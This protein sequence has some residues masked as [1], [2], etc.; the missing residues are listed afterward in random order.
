MSDKDNTIILELMASKICHDL[1]SPVGAISN[2]VEILEDMGDDDAGEVVSLIA[3]SAEQAN[4]KLKTL[5][6]AYGLGGSDDSIR[7]EEVHANFESFISAEKRL[8]QD[9]DPYADLGIE[10]VKGLAKMLLCSLMLAMESLPKGGVISVKKSDNNVMLIT[11]NGENARFRDGV[12]HALAHTIDI[13]D[14][15]PKL[16]HPY[17]T[18]LLAKTYEFKL[19]VDETE[20]NFIFLR[21]EHTPVS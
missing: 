21:L 4:A 11:A 2:G 13:N 18:G 16:T 7:I 3:F 19:T 8:S 15:E 10:P 14:L 17:I 6:M 12:L 9:W 1:I 5:R 20:N